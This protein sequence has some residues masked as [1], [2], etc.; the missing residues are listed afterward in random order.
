MP[1]ERAQRLR[2]L[3][4]STQ[5][6]IFHPIHG[7]ATLITST[8]ISKGHERAKAKTAARKFKAFLKKHPQ[9]KG[10]TFY[11]REWKQRHGIE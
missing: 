2:G 5:Q 9:D 10:G 3:P 8:F 7:K 6:T 4:Q 1:K 11:S